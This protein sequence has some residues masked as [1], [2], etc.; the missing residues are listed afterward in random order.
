MKHVVKASYDDHNLGAHKE[1]YPPCQID[2][3]DSS[4]DVDMLRFR[5]CISIV[6]E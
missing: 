4:L 3:N 1:D 2:M 6:N 5:I